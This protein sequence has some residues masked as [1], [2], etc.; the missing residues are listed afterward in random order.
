[1]K[2]AVKKAAPAVVQINTLGGTDIVVGGARGT[3][4]RKAIGP[5]TGV[6]IA[7]DGYVISSAFNFVNQPKTILVSVPGHKK[8]YRAKVLANDDSRMLPLLTIEATGLPVPASVPKKEIKVGQWSIALGRT[9]DPNI[10]NLPSISVGIVSALDRIW[11]KAIQ[12]D[13]K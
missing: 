4:I 9:L 3:Q 6:I 2:A 1:E 5:T 7:A 8:P 12:T 11:G 10:S 13:G